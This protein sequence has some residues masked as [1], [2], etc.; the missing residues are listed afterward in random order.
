MSRILYKYL[1]PSRA[2]VLL[3][4]TIRFSQV[5]ALNDPFESRALIH[6]DQL[7]AD[8]IEQSNNEFDDFAKGW[9]EDNLSAEDLIELERGKAELAAWTRHRMAPERL[10]RDLM[11]FLN[12]N[13]GVLSLSRTKKSLLL[14]AHYAE[15]HTG[16]A[17]GMDRDD[18]FF[19]QADADGVPTKI[20]DVLYLP[21]RQKVAHGVKTGSDYQALLCQ[22]SEVWK[23]EEEVRVFRVLT[24]ATRTGFKDAQGYPVHLCGIPKSAIKEVI[25][26]ANSSY[27][28]QSNI[29]RYL[30]LHQIKA[31]VFRARML[32]DSFDMVF[33][34]L[35][36]QPYR[37][38]GYYEVEYSF[39]RAEHAFA[40]DM[41]SVLEA[42]FGDRYSGFVGFGVPLPSARPI[43][44]KV[45]GER[46]TWSGSQFFLDADNGV[47]WS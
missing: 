38:E 4:G 9:N 34:E 26:G 15:G 44:G 35:G 42:E 12:T 18:P 7:I 33:D 14:W 46:V 36:L 22:K 5:G 40:S 24:K 47:V 45:E 43:L 11:R 41:L 32:D 37:D 21:A 8:F 1:P 30:K 17:I 28:L 13:L 3:T 6:A 39:P 2:S 29:R 19:S 25:F 31:S 10:G 20:H 16:F 23:Y 27:R